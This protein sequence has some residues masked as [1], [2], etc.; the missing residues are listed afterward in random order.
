[1]CRLLDTVARA[2]DRLL[3]QVLSHTRTPAGFFDLLVDLVT[4]GILFQMSRPYG[5]TAAPLPLEGYL[6]L[7]VFTVGWIL[8]VVGSYKVVGEYKEPRD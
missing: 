8:I 4:A 7:A 5:V 1:M 2:I 6:P 3:D